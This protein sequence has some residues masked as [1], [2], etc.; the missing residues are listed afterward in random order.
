MRLG[1]SDNLGPLRPRLRRTSSQV[2]LVAPATDEC[3]NK[4]ARILKT[5][6]EGLSPHARQL[7]HRPPPQR[8]ARRKSRIPRGL[9]APSPSLAAA[10]ARIYPSRSFCT[11]ATTAEGRHR[12]PN[13]SLASPAPPA[14]QNYG[15]RGSPQREAVAIWRKPEGG[16]PPLS[17][18]KAPAPRHRMQNDGVRN[19]E[20]RRGAPALRR[21]SAGTG[22]SRIEEAT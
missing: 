3:Q 2:P 20:R 13:L 14:R 11:L 9:S 21:T 4:V 15:K 5:C 10:S 22:R 6:T 19:A 18:G 17:T 1:L 12:T 7:K 16:T 8:F